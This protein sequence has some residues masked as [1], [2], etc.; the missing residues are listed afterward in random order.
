M[1]KIVQFIFEIVLGTAIM[2]F[3]SLFAIWGNTKYLGIAIIGIGVFIYF[4]AIA[5]NPKNTDK[6]S[7]LKMSNIKRSLTIL[8]CLVAAFIFLFVDINNTN[9][10]IDTNTSTTSTTEET[11]YKA[12]N[13][14]EYKVQIKE[15]YKSKGFYDEKLVVVVFTFT[16]KSDEAICFND[17]I[18]VQAFQNGVELNLYIATNIPGQVDVRDS[19]KELKP[20][21][22]YDVPKAY[23]LDDTE[24]SVEIE[25]SNQF[26]FEPI[27]YTITL[28]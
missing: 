17:A 19:Y 12:S 21:A 25:L 4:V 9:T 5:N 2:F 20:G 7:K 28:N 18:D 22:S 16:N 1:L 8:L 11:T 3:G 6:P 24:N 23:I 10:N 26:V 13:L 27:T 14:G 15:H